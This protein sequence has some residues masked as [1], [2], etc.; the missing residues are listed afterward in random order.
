[1]VP[2]GVLEANRWL[3]DDT[4]TFRVCRLIRLVRR[5]SVSLTTKVWP[6]LSE[7]GFTSVTSMT[8][9]Q[10]LGIE[11]GTHIDLLLQKHS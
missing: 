11:S 6:K 9:R 5:N 2:W 7:L 3:V 1:M 8:T 10:V 4:L